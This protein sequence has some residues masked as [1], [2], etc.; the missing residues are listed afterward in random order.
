ML[1]IMDGLPGLSGKGGFSPITNMRPCFYI[2]S[3]THSSH[4]NTHFTLC[5]A[6]FASASTTARFYNASFAPDLTRKEVLVAGGASGCEGVLPD[7]TNMVMVV[8]VLVTPLQ[9]L[10]EGGG[11]TFSGSAY[12]GSKQVNIALTLEQLLNKKCPPYTYISISYRHMNAL[13]YPY[14]CSHQ[15][16]YTCSYYCPSPSQ[17]Y[18]GWIKSLNFGTYDS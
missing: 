2:H 10:Q 7:L 5:T 3:H 6:C 14:K 11:G 16:C 1:I 15:E 17:W 9:W 4:T 18:V 8:L 13:P 12:T